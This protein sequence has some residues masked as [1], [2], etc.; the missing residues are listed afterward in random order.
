M[1]IE[2]IIVETLPLKRG[3]GAGGGV[4]G[5]VSF[6]NFPK[7]G[8]SDF[9]HKKEGLVKQPGYFKNAVFTLSLIFVLH[10]PFKSYLVQS[11]W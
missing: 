9:F 4:G 8:G 6:Q 3:G 11:E 1:V 2:T 7:K 5:G 10:N